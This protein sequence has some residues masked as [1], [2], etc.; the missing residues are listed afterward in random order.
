MNE[1]TTP[2]IKQFT[3]CA[4]LAAIGIKLRELK[5]FQPIKQSVQIAQKT[6]KHSPTDKLYD[7][8]ISRLPAAHGLV[9]INTR[10]RAD[11]ALP[12]ACART[13]S[14]EQSVVQ[15]TLDA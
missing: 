3:G 8:F 1:S 13:R 12:R 10:L 5:V 11:S 6:I 9:E 15:A 7:A 4:T 2:L 14:A